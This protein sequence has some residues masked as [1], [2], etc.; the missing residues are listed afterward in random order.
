MT[1]WEYKIVEI[2]R[3]EMDRAADIFNDLGDSG[4]EMVALSDAS[5]CVIFKREVSILQQR[6]PVK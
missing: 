1:R 3:A 4:W 6:G 5:K 2:T